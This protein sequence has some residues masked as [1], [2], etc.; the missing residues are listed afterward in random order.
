V[1]KTKKAREPRELPEKKTRGQELHRLP[2]HNIEVPRRYSIS[3]RTI[4]PYPGAIS[5]PWKQSGAI[6]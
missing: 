4:S 6:Q 2:E 3:Q 1:K 5:V